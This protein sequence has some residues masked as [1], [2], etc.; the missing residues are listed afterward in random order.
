MYPVTVAEMGEHLRLDSDVLTA[1]TALLTAMIKSATRIAENWTKRT[2]VVSTYTAY[3]DYFYPCAEYTIRR[4]PLISIESIEYYID[5][6]LT[7][8]ANTN[9]R[10]TVSDDFSKL[11]AVDSWPTDVDDR[12]Q[13]IKISFTAGYP[14]DTTPDPDA[15]T[16]YQDIKEAIKQHV[17]SMWTKRGDCSQDMIGTRGTAIASGSL[18]QFSKM[19][20]NQNRILDIYVGM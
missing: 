18:P 15:S 7:E 17:A 16:V 4:G 5:D 10:I 2:L 6:V 9:Y 1:E 20:Y 11:V 12:E 3:L 8:W 13:A 19:V 14:D